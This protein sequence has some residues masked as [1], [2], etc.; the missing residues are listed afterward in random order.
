MKSKHIVGLICAASAAA[1]LAGPACAQGT[2][3]KIGAVLPMSGNAA[4]A[5]VHAKAAFEVAM[6][7][8]NNAHPELGSFPLAKNAGLA[9][10]EPERSHTAPGGQPDQRGFAARRHRLGAD[11]L[12]GLSQRQAI[13][14]RPTLLP[15][16][17]RRM[18][19]RAVPLASR[20]DC[21]IH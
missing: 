16:R 12:I 21:P 2:T 5:G 9:G 3:V 20:L 18:L 7:I 11:D 8:I 17:L 6:D 10:L 19:Q 15:R 4:S 13:R 14:R 1:V